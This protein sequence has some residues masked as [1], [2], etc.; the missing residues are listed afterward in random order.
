MDMSRWQGRERPFKVVPFC[1]WLVL[2]LGIGAQT[3]FH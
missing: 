3:A 2:G 1:A